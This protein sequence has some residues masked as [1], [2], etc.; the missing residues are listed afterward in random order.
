MIKDFFYFSIINLR[1]RKLR[2]W[3]TVTGVIIGIAAVVALLSLSAGLTQE[4]ERQFQMFGS[5]KLFITPR[6]TGAATTLGGGAGSLVAKDLDT[7]RGINVI[8]NAAG[9]LRRSEPVKFKD[10]VQ[11]VTVVGISTDTETEKLFQ[12]VQGF[13]INQGRQLKPGDEFKAGIGS[14][15]ASNMFKEPVKARDDLEIAGRTVKVVGTYLP[16]GNLQDDS[17]IVMP[18][19][20]LREI[21][22]EKDALTAI[23]AKVK[24][25]VNIDDAKNE[26]LKDLRKAKNQKE[27]EETFEVSTSQDILRLVNQ[28]FG[29]IQFVLVGIG[30]ISLIVGAVGV[31]NT[32]YTSVLDRTKEIGIMKAVGAKNSDVMKIFLIE[33]AVIGTIG[34]AVGIVLGA[35]M[36]KIVEY[37]AGAVLLVPLKAY[38]GPDLIAGALVLS[39]VIGTVA[40][41]LPAR[42]AASLEP[43]EALRYE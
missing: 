8:D 30:A 1:R 10:E 37:L 4:V 5:D 13:K 43:V 18:I 6:I 15:F 23:F 28:L 24:A 21:T 33:S 20:S 7:V 22:G 3:L 32:M 11:Y 39:L 2:S 27:N 38:T 12:E 35:L 41:L 36:G 29:T 19:S 14:Y 40:G 16:I 26:T 9:I 42:K 34:G 25:G 17:M 31:T